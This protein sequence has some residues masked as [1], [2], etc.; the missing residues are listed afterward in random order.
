MMAST[1]GYL[2]LKVSKTK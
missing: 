2:R 1:D